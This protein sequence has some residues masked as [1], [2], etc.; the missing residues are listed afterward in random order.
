MDVSDQLY[1]PAALPPG[2]RCRYQLD[3]KLGGPQNR[4][5]QG[6][7]EKNSQPPPGNESPTNDRPARSQSL[8][9]LSYHGVVKVKIGACSPRYNKC[10]S[11]G[12]QL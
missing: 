1:Y 12:R 10:M 3:R 8:Y 7:E 9:R 4:S 2:K 11:L 5:G 6:A